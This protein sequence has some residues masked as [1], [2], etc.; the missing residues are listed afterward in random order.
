MHSCKAK[1]A[2][3]PI[4]PQWQPFSNDALAMLANHQLQAQKRIA[5]IA[6]DNKKTALAAWAH[7]HQ[8]TLC[9]H[10]LFATA[11]TGAL[12][13]ETL[14]L[15]VHCYQSGPLGGDLQIGAA[16]TEKRIDM[17]IFFW[18]P[19]A[20][21]PH[22][23]DVKALLR[24]AVVWNVPLACNSSTADFLISS[25]YFNAPYGIQTDESPR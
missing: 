18:D 16:V 21:Q 7:A 2:M 20:A 22:D 13:R 1:R 17:L 10:H 3:P 25:P 6:H 23:P 12:L 14:G 8:N 15:N 24:L 9:Q 4:Q 19:L 5:M 11:T